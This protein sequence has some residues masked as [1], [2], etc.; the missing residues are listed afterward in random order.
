[1]S[2]REY[3]AR[4]LRRAMLAISALTVFSLVAMSGG[5][6]SA[7]LAQSPQGRI[8]SKSD[9]A[10]ARVHPLLRQQAKDAPNSYVMVHAYVQAGTDLSAYMPDA[11]APAYAAPSGF[12][13]V[14][15][16]VAARNLTK[17]AGVPGVSSV[18]PLR[19]AAAP[20]IDPD[21]SAGSNRTLPDADALSQMSRTMQTGSRGN[22]SVTDTG[23]QPTGWYDV[24]GG[25]DSA[26]AWDKGYTGA[27]VKVMVND[28]GIDFAHPDLMD[29]WARITD[30]SSPYYGWPEMFDQYSVYLLA[31]DYYLGEANVANGASSYADTSAVISAGNASYQP[32][33]ADAANT[34]TLPGTSK[35]GE[36]HIGTHPDNSLRLWYRIVNGLPLFDED[37]PL[38]DERPAVLVV[39][40]GTPGVYDTV[41]V[42]LDFDNDFTNEKPARRGDEIVGADWWG[43]IDPETGEFAAEPDGFYDQSGGLVYWISDGV[44]GVPTADWWWGIDPAF[45]GNGNL[46]AFSFSHWWD[47]PAGDHGQLCAS[48]VAG[49]GRTNADSYATGFAPDFKP[50]GTTGMVTGAGKDVQLVD[51]GDFYSWG[52]T[53]AFYFAALGYDG[54]PGTEDDIQVMSNSWGSSFDHNDGWDALSREIDA[55][56]RWINPTL[57]V[58]SSSGNGAPG[59]GTTT[60]PSPDS[61]LQVGASTQYG[62]TGF[63]SA[64]GADQITHGDVIS[65]SG[66]GPD[67]KGGTGIELVA[68]GS[69]GAG[70]A[71]LNDALTGANAWYT[72][73]G[74]SRSGPVAAGN[75]ALM[76][77]AYQ[78]MTGSWPDYETAKAILMSGAR[79]LHYDPFLQGT[80]SVNGNRAVDIAS[81]MAGGFVTPSSWI[82]G[83]YRGDVY[84]GF[85]NIMKPGETSEMT[86]TVHNPSDHAVRYDIGDRWLQR[87]NSWQMQFTS[88]SIY[89]E[90][91]AIEPDA[92]SS[93]GVNTN[94]PHYL[95][96]LTDQ[97]SADTDLFVV[98]LNLPYGEWDPEGSYS[99]TRPNNWRI[100]AYDWTDV[101]GDGNLWSDDDGNG[102]ISDDEIDHGEYVRFNYGYNTSSSNTVTIQRPLER[103]HDGFFIGLIHDQVREDVPQTDLTFTMEEYQ[104]VDFGWLE[105]RSS[106]VDVPARST[107]TVRATVTVPGDAA[108]GIYEGALLFNDGNWTS[109]VPVTINVA[110]SSARFTAGGEDGNSGE[111]YY[112]N[113]RVYGAQAWDWRAESGDWRFFYIDNGEG[114]G[115]S[116][117]ALG[118]WANGTRYMMVDAQWQNMPT[119]LN[120]YM[121]GPTDDCFSTPIDPDDCPYPFDVYDPDFYGPYT[122]EQIGGSDAYFV[123]PGVYLTQTTSGSNREFVAAPYLPGLNM[124]AVHNV[125]YAGMPDAEQFS[126]QAGTLKVSNAPI[127]VS[128]SSGQA[129]VTVEESISSSM[130][131]SGLVVQGF[132]MSTPDVMTG[133]P[134]SQDDPNDPFSASYQQEITV[135]HAGLLEISTHGQE[136]DDIDL[137][138]I[139][140]ANGDG[141]YTGDELV[142]ASTT[143]TAEEFIRLTL[144]A[145]GNYL[146]LAQGWSIPLEESTFDLTVNLVQGDDISVTGLPEDPIT[147]GFPYTFNI[148]MNLEGYAPGVYQGIVTLGPPEGPAAII[149][150]VTFEVRE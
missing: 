22:V 73:G 26:L 79:D 88:S 80:G 53:D 101:N 130:A 111:G 64:T 83:S 86:F 5:S 51:A 2:H 81:G 103:M 47:S 68:N 12:T 136:G 18:M 21:A 141:E 125:N 48:N 74:T 9:A 123:G 54:V 110:G 60:S 102:T 42:D 87:Q 82:A 148:N 49:Q 142:A 29:T 45:I 56:V 114:A 119:D 19:G 105:S 94:Q 127:E 34:Y 77:Q 90:N 38:H 33:D 32:L 61:G 146:I 92:P 134:I 67:S 17:L 20:A 35:S 145:S 116:A 138:L 69:V 66:R 13:T 65:W 50:E 84:E 122:L 124:V 28:S 30:E 44:S 23:A 144:P 71:P 72:W 52:G 99:P 112:D 100:Y 98:R 115:P 108:L 7:G 31:R 97:V 143:A 6:P 118:R 14:T 126:I 106:S 121:F 139:Y 43:A 4:R 10:V 129:N 132:G 8:V 149:I 46:V 78:Q 62:S 96:N 95:W 133:L 70:A 25:H 75:A 140:D 3:G 59:F 93:T 1:M 57:L 128:R 16:T 76:Y 91:V 63:D 135:D 39:D 58:V 24:L 150:P 104:Q 11:L 37:E 137:F 113:S 36:Y 15:G 109:N 27:G 147:P 120:V 117:G 131:L 89:E 85:T 55:I 107:A 41:Y 40:E